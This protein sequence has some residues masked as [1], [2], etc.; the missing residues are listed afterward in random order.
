M[1]AKVRI[2]IYIFLNKIIIEVD[3]YTQ[4]GFLLKN[5]KIC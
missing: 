3:I 1:I 2:N 5:L 4:K